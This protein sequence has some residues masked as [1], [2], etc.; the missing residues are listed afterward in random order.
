MGFADLYIHALSASNL[1][2]DERHHQAEPLTASAF[3]AASTGD[4]APLLQRAKYAGT[5]SQNMAVAVEVRERTEKHLLDAIRNKDTGREAECR[6]ALEGDATV[7]EGSAAH[8]V[9]LLHLWTA[10]VTKRGRA[11]RWVKEGT[12]WDIEAAQKLYRT[13]AQAS[14]AYWLNS[15]CPCCAGTGVVQKYQCRPCEGSGKVALDVK[16]AFVLE[17][18]KDMVSELQSIVDGHSMRAASKLRT[19]T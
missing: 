18:T 10:E 2:D 13:V 14:L 7:L 6:Q 17:R 19:T 1:K 11:R 9:R 5:A 12:A 4:L 8:L 15:T 3:A 16:G